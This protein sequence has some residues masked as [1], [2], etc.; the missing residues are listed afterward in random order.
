MKRVLSLV[1]AVLMLF[2]LTAFAD[3][4]D[5]LSNP[6]TSYEADISVTLT[7]NEPMTVLNI[8]SASFGIDNFVN[9]QALAESLANSKSTGSVKLNASSDYTKAKMSYEVL[10]VAPITV[11]RNFKLTTEMKLG[12]WLEWDF[13]NELNPVMKYIVQ[14]PLMDKYMSVDLVEMMTS[15][16]LSVPDIISSVKGF[17]VEERINDLNSKFTDILRQNSTLTSKGNK[18]TI[19]LTDTQLQNFIAQIMDFVVKEFDD[20]EDYNLLH[21]GDFGYISDVLP[22]YDEII[23]FFSEFQLF[24]ENALV[25]EYVKNPS[26]T[27]KNASVSFNMDINLEKALDG[28]G[29]YA[30]DSP[31]NLKFSIKTDASYKSVNKNVKVS[32][33]SLTENDIVNFDDFIGGMNYEYEWDGEN[34]YHDEYGHVYNEYL[35]SSKDTFY[36]SLSNIIESHRSYGYDYVIERNGDLI[37]LTDASGKECFKK[38]YLSVNSNEIDVDGVKY[39]LPNSVIVKDGIIYIDSN[40]IKYIFNLDLEYAGVDLETNEL[41]C[42]FTRRS[43]QCHHT[44]E[45]I[46]G[47]EAE[48]GD[49]E[50]CEHYQHVYVWSDYPYDGVGY[51]KIRDIINEIA[52]VCG[53]SYEKGVLTLTDP[54]GESGFGTVVITVGSNEY[55]VDGMTITSGKPAIEY[56]DSVYIDESAAFPIFGFETFNPSLEYTRNYNEDGTIQ[57]SYMSYN[58]RLVRKS[59]LCPHTD[60]RIRLRE[61]ERW[62]SASNQRPN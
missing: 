42:S 31:K 16:G 40:A 14:Q 18:I 52:H 24:D 51:I 17:F 10:E 19:T 28:M 25:M 4:Y 12:M 41:T 35:P 59:P 13:S 54:T 5:V 30:S 32:F 57:N 62:R 58:A 20:N 3:E 26:G 44:E 29:I 61:Q 11:N 6:Y 8:I 36:V 47:W 56:N 33:P 22:S 27:I 39:T 9:L 48:Y 53:I 49:T 43:P 21:D 2:S 45:E 60:P 55:I 37:V 34:C 23:E 7:V 15:Q 50:E 46:N 1:V 38:A